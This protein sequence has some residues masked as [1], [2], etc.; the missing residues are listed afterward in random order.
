[1]S[2]RSG[3]VDDGGQDLGQGVSGL[4]GTEVRGVGGGP[5]H[6]YSDQPILRV[7]L[8]MRRGNF[9]V[10]KAKQVIAA[11]TFTTIISAYRASLS[12]QYT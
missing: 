7:N 5:V 8:F 1:M 10:R 9:Q 6:T 4:E 11:Y 2:A 12:T 3:G